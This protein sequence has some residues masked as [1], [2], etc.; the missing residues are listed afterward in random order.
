[1]EIVQTPNNLH[2]QV[3]IRVRQHW[4]DTPIAL[5]QMHTKIAQTLSRSISSIWSVNMA[6]LHG[7]YSS[8]R[9]NLSYFDS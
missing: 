8:N 2:F 4:P 1:M 6:T 5:F 7:R 9:G 3:S